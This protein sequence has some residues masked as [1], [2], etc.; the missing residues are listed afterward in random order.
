M[1]ARSSVRSVETRSYSPCGE[2]DRGVGG[3][4]A[5]RVAEG[6]GKGAGCVREMLDA[7]LRRAST[8]CFWRN[9]IC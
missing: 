3:R 2:S 8:D 5:G 6:R 4:G 7:E 9:E 1:P